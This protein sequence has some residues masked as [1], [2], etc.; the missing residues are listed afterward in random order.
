MGQKLDTEKIAKGL[1]ARR[2]STV[3]FSGAT[4]A[5]CSSQPRLPSGFV[6]PKEVDWLIPLSPATLRRLEELADRLDATPLQVAA[7]LLE[8]SVGQIAD[9]E[10]AQLARSASLAAEA[11]LG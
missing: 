10:V 5:R 2:V 3:R 6:F 4:S 11:K 1:R 7:L 9:E 8:K